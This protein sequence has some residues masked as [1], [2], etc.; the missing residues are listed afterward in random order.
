MFKIVH[1]QKA[2]NEQGVSIESGGRF[3]TIYSDGVREMNFAKEGGFDEKGNHVLNIRWRLPLK[4]NPPHH[5]EIVSVEDAE[6]IKANITE[7]V[8]VLGS[9]PKFTDI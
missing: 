6:K 3:T 4:W 1:P 5:E 7:A 8:A 9:I 2:E